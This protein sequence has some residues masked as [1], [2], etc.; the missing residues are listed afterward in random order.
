MERLAAKARTLLVQAIDDRL[1]AER[2]ASGAERQGKYLTYDGR[3]R[4]VDC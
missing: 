4:L 2:H 3:L 1:D